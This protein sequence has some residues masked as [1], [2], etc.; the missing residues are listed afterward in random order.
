MRFLVFLF[1]VC[2]ATVVDANQSNQLNLGKQSFNRVP[3]DELNSFERTA[4]KL[5]S[6]LPELDER[7]ALSR[8]FKAFNYHL[9]GS[10]KLPKL[11][12]TKSNAPWAHFYLQTKD[13]KDC[14]V[15]L[16]V[17]I[18]TAINNIAFRLFQKECQ[19]IA[20]ARLHPDSKDRALAFYAPWKH[21]QTYFHY[22]LK[23]FGQAKSQA[24]HIQVYALEHFIK[25][26]EVN[27]IKMMISHSMPI[28]S[29][30]L[31]T[32]QACLSKKLGIQVDVFNNK[33]AYFEDLQV[34]QRETVSDI[35][36]FIRIG[37]SSEYAKSIAKNTAVID[38][39]DDCLLSR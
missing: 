30:Q 17:A 15:S 36:Q 3:F 28:V 14:V 33:Q 19:A 35:S 39:I 11:V 31:K 32:A 18:D 4:I 6:S 27:D 2:I 12:P 24:K 37:F 21:P 9:V 22:F 23:A 26:P 38:A 1:C 16:P 29:E 34:V 10:S 5:I 8:D 13:K 20:I 25:P 7:E